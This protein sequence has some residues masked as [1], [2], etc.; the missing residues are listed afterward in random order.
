MTVGG[1][2]KFPPPI[3]EDTTLIAYPTNSGGCS[4]NIQRN[5]GL[6]FIKD[7]FVYFL[8]D[9]NIV[10]PNMFKRFENEREDLA[11]V[12]NQIHK[13]GRVRLF[14]HPINM[15][16]GGVDTAQFLIPSYMIKNRIWEPYNYCADGVLFPQIFQ[17]H[18]PGFKFLQENLSYYNY[19][20]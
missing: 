4:G 7:G 9:D 16:V 10:H 2:L 1:G 11:Y 17:D 5:H 13:D 6:K 19:L 3:W 14:A 18:K 8:D 12:V 15:K 20:R